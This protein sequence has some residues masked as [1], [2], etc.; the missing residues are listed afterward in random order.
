MHPTFANVRVIPTSVGIHTEAIYLDSRLH[1][2]DR[3]TKLNNEVFAILRMHPHAVEMHSIYARNHDIGIR[4]D[5]GMARSRCQGCMSLF[6]P[7]S[8][9]LSQAWEK[10]DDGFAPLRPIVGEGAGG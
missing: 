9:S 10:D 3:P 1:G 4:S 5:S 7:L 8:K 6:R 2:N